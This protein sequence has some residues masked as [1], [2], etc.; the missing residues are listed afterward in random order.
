MIN[1]L[2]E[3]F[4]TR[5]LTRIRLCYFLIGFFACACSPVQPHEKVST[6]RLEGNSDFQVYL[7]LH[8]MRIPN[9]EAEE[10]PLD[11]F[12]AFSLR[13]TLGGNIDWAGEPPRY[14]VD[15]GAAAAE[16]VTFRARNVSLLEILLFLERTH[17]VHFIS[18]SRGLEISAK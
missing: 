7:L 15:L 2:L 13:K 18:G 5:A 14:N 16:K 12:I 11:E 17:G 4:I 6:P 9:I 3:A 8:R 1:Y 10:M